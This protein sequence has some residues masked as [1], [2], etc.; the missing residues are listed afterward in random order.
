MRIFVAGLGV[1]SCIGRDTEEN[2]SSL[3]SGQHGIDALSDE[4]DP[5]MAGYP[6]G[7]VK[8]SNPELAA[9][10]G[11]GCRWP[12]AALLSLHA[13]KEALQGIHRSDQ[14]RI[15][16]F[17][18]TT[19]GGMDYSE[20]GWASWQRTGQ[21]PLRGFVNHECGK[22]TEL[23]ADRLGING[24]VTTV[25]TACSSSANS[26]VMAARLLKQGAI[27]VALA[28][29][30][31]AITVFTLNGFNTLLIYDT[32]LCRPF[33]AK[34]GGLNLGEGAGYL[35][36]AGEKGLRMTGAE[37]VCELAGSAN[38]NDAFHQTASSP[39]GV[40]SFLAMSKALET[41]GV[42]P[43]HVDYI[44]LHGTGTENND[45]S[46]ATA[47]RRLFG[48]AI[49]PYSSTKGFTGHTLGASGGIEAVYACMAIRNRTIFPNIRFAEPLAEAGCVPV[50]E[51]TRRDVHIAMS[52]SFG[53]GGNC[54]SLLFKRN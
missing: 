20:K 9:A 48:D 51:T 31:D 10:T 7:R 11:G 40:G 39:E 24:F 33:D 37:P 1:I 21:I 18:A 23:V 22:V 2:F 35:L 3:V 53:F 36:L 32:Q 6:V 16:F 54:T 34:R 14:L 12:R 43:G 41:G 49:P 44:N 47:I 13:A 15:G 28:G 38:A 29:G 8:V 42:I 30:A 52:N 26:I 50:T 25:N 45:A 46:E 19:V 4:Y 27:D 17:S 5:Q